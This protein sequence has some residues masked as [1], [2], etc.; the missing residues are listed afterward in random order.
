VAR[1]EQTTALTVGDLHRALEDIA[2][3]RLAEP[4]D[5]V[6]LQLGAMDAPAGRVMLALEVTPL[7]L[8][9]ARRR[10]V[11]TLVTH[12]PLIFSGLKSL[13]VTDPVTSM[14]ATMMA[15]G[16]NLIAA[17]TNLDSVM[18]GTNGEIADRLG[19]A[20]RSFLQPAATPPSQCK[21]SVFVPRTHVASLI[22]AF[23]EGGAGVIGN[24]SHC[25][26][27]TP[28]VGTFRPLEGANPYT[29]QVG[30]L[31]EAGDE[32]RLEAVCP[33]ASLEQVIAGVRRAHPYEEMAYD[34]FPLQPHGPARHGLGIVGELPAAVGLSEF[35]GLCKEAFGVH[36]VG[37]VEA[38][39]KRVRRVAICSGGGGSLVGKAAASGAEVFVVG[40][41]THHHCADARDR[42]LAMVLVGHHASEVIVA[43]RLARLLREHPLL[44]ARRPDIIVS[45]SERGPVDR[46]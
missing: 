5:N 30:Q 15:A 25:T 26:F 39:R 38:G 18:E 2:P 31:E 1:R 9:E 6:G 46:V 33:L 23:A 41:A 22:D 35:V 37:L 29:G 36:S 42:G 17:H 3:F 20:K 28:G 34:V 13:A 44:A 4:W 16:M 43:P 32:V 10:K 27:R 7:V 12:H 21:V 40:E 11:S 24:Y 14:V 45:A 19:L 8:A